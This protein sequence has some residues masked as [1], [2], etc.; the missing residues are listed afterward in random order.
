MITTAIMIFW[1]CVLVLAYTFAGYPLML[2]ALGRLY[3]RRVHKQPISVSVTFIVPA[4]NE[5][6][7]IQRKIENIRQLEYPR[8]LIQIIVV[9]DASTDDTAQRCREFEDVIIVELDDRSGKSAALNAGLKLATGNLIAFT[10]ASIMLRPDS[11]RRAVEPFADP[12][13]GCVSSEDEVVSL[14]GIGTGEGFYTRLDAYSRRVEGQ[15]SSATGMSGSFH[16][17]R[18]ELCPVFPGAVATDMFAALFC[19]S[20]GYRAIVEESSKVEVKAQA[21]TKRE[22]GRK[23]RTMLTGLSAVFEVPRLLNPFKYGLFSWCLFSHKVLRYLTPIFTALIL[24]SSFYLAFSSNFFKTIVALECLAICAAL[25]VNNKKT[26]THIPRIIA[27]PAFFG[28]T[29]SAA[30]V[31]L[32]RYIKGD[33]AIAWQPTERNAGMKYPSQGNPE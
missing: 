13:V 19:V 33:R 31:A 4:H 20:R 11:L 24:V 32:F 3:P 18:R 26:N 5:G 29:V 2:A 15:V 30:A 14:G 10:D 7:I 22:F 8:D 1:F 28:I 25:F 16:L 12:K 9:S 27:I 23:V 17:V 6:K 21:D